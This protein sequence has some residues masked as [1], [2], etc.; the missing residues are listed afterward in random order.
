M[1]V[2]GGRWLGCVLFRRR[3]VRGLGSSSTSVLVPGIFSSPSS[4]GPQFPQALRSLTAPAPS[5]CFF[6]DFG[7]FSGVRLDVYQDRCGQ[8]GRFSAVLGEMFL[9]VRLR[10][11]TL[12]C[13]R[14]CPTG[15]SDFSGSV[16]LQSF[17]WAQLRGIFSWVD[18][19]RARMA[20]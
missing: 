11:R 13:R 18:G 8:T 2:V 5:H 7:K 19:S 14:G 6:S 16:S 20:G 3:G 9:C 10:H 17:W 12:R 4:G 15:F 1:E